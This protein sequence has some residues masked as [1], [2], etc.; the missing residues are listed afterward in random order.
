[1]GWV[2]TAIE[3]SALAI[4]Q[5]YRYR[6]VSTPLERQ[7]TKWVLVGFAA[8]V[9]LVGALSIG[10]LLAA[11]LGA[12][13][14][15]VTLLT[16]NVGFVLPF[17]LAV[18]FGFAMLRSRLWEI[19]RLINRALVYGTLTLVLAALYVSLVIGL[20]TLSRGV[21]G[22]DSSIVIVLST[23]VIAALIAPLRRWIQAF[24]DRRFYRSRYDAARILQAFSDGLRHE[25]RVEAVREQLLTAVSETMHPAHASLWLRAAPERERSDLGPVQTPDVSG[26]PPDVGQSDA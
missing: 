26:A 19:D 15:I 3:L 5:L 13:T 7:Q 23:L 20:Q 24:I 6:V 10:A 12:S 21:T 8:P 1:L 2:V 14:G 4:A 9:S 18:G 11:A 16:S 22:Q 25:T 17:G